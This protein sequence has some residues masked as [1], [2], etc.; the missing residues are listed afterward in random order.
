MISFE[1]NKIQ[2]TAGDGCQESRC[3]MAFELRRE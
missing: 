1:G 2:A 3:E